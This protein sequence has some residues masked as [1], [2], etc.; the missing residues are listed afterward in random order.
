MGRPKMSRVNLMVDEETR[1][2][3]WELADRLGLKSM[4]A[5]VRL[6]VRELAKKEGL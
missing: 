6:A 3:M 4:S 1:R 2:L 5:V